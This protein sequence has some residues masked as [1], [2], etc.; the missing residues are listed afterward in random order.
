M[1]LDILAPVLAAPL[2]AG[3]AGPGAPRPGHCDNGVAGSVSR[4][5]GDFVRGPSHLAGVPGIQVRLL[6]GAGQAVAETRTAATGR[7]S[8]EGICAGSYVVCPGTPCPAGGPVPS[9]YDPPSRHI[10]L[11]R[12][13][14]KNVN[15][16]MTEPEGREPGRGF[17]DSFFHIDDGIREARDMELAKSVRDFVSRT[18]TCPDE[19]ACHLTV[20]VSNGNVRLRGTVPAAERIRLQ[21]I[22]ASV[23]GVRS[24]DITQVKGKEQP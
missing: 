24:L 3:L 4:R 17:D 21:K 15:F 23:A 20:S 2:L 6:D 9:R 12:S 10:V 18:L 5:V 16:R 22:A 13:P 19:A 14:N 11:P 1:M 8:F 7:Y